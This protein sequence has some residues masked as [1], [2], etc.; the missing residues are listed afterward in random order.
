MTGR[1]MGAV[2]QVPC[3]PL[4]TIPGEFVSPMSQRIRADALR[5]PVRLQQA[6]IIEAINENRILIIAGPQGCGKSTQLPQVLL[7][8]CFARSQR[9]R[10]IC[11]QPRRL[12]AHANA[13]RVANERGETVGQ[14]IGYQIR[15]ESK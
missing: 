1:L 12:A 6:Q 3:A 5:L 14:S 11:T 7:E 9:C 4:S 8:D 2:P 15:L 13:D 10:A